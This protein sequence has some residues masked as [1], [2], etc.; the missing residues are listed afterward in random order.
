MKDNRVKKMVQ[1]AILTAIIIIMAFT[2]LG[3]LKIGVVSITFLMLPV[4]LGSIVMGPGYGAVLGG[5]FGL[6]SF[7]QCFGMD[8]FGTTI[9]GLNPFYAFIVCMLPR[10]LMG[11]LSGLIFKGLYRIDKTKVVS[12]AVSSIS[13]ALLNTGLFTLTFVLLYGS[14]QELI[15]ALIDQN[16]ISLGTIWALV[17]IFITV[18][19]IWEA[20]IC[21]VVGTPLCKALYRF[22]PEK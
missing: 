5:I 8:W 13:G 17:G 14:N 4:V 2:P 16:Y 11:L 12:F 20:I 22:K 10:I 9:F 6:T 15:R 3:Y 1:M 21:L 18:N 19:L 7:V